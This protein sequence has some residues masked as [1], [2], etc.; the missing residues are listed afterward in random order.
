MENEK[1]QAAIASAFSQLT[2]AW[3]AGVGKM[4]TEP[5]GGQSHTLSS[6]C[7]MSALCW[8][9]HAEDVRLSQHKQVATGIPI[10]G[11]E[12]EILKA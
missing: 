11:E 4:S 10:T 6:A 8:A 9:V 7:G 2:S 3:P 12:T 5:G 1:E